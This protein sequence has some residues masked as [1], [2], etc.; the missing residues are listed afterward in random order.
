MNNIRNFCILAHIDHGKSTLADRFLEMTGSVAERKMRA[1]YLDQMELEKEKGITIKMQPVRMRYA[2]PINADQDADLRGLLYEDITYQVRGAVFNVYNALG[3]SFKESIYQRALEEEFV[4][5]GIVFQKE[6]SIPVVYADKNVGV[7]R[8]DFV[9]DEKVIVEIKALPF[10]GKL[11]QKQVWHYLKGSKYRLALLINFGSKNL[12]IERVVY[13]SIRDYP[14]LDPHKSAYILNL[15][16]TPGHADFSY[17]VSRALAAVEG[18]ILLVDATQG[19]QAQTLANLHAA[20]HEGLGIIPVINKIDLPSADV[21]KTEEELCATLGVAQNDILKISAKTGQGVE[22]LLRA[23]ARLVPPP[24]MNNQLSMAGDQPLRAL[25]FDSKYDPYLGVV[26]HIRI[27]EGILKKGERIF[28]MASG[29]DAEALEVGVF[30]PE[31]SEAA[32]LSAGEIGYVATGLKQS[33]AVRV[34][35]TIIKSK[36]Q[37]SNV[38]TNAGLEEKILPLVGYREPVPMVFAS[39]FLEDQHEYETLRN[40][41]DKLKLEDAA[42]TFVPEDAGALGRG[43]RAG[44]LGLLHMEIIAERIQREYD[45]RLVLTRPSVAFRMMMRAGSSAQAGGE[46]VMVYS[47]SRLPPAQ[48]IIS[49][50]EPWVRAEAVT[51]AAYLGSLAGLISESGGMMGDT[52]TLASDRLLVSFE[53][54]LREVIIDFYDKL[55]SVSH[56][57]ASFSYEPIGYRPG[58]LVRLDIIIADEIQPSLSEIVPAKEAEVIGRDRIKALKALLPA[59][60]FAIALQAAVGGRI[61]ARETIAAVKKDVTAHMYGGDRTRK[62]K[63]WKKQ[64]KG[65]KRLKETGRVKIPPEIFFKLHRR[66]GV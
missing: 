54:P 60:L 65:K 6:K 3:G 47:A 13:D 49:L 22:E 46:P 51:P 31:R 28:F 4:R 38:K 32:G 62:M 9:I 48:E 24:R 20:R 41:L 34:G 40:A 2:P 1:Q 37:I 29:A 63:L 21:K 66:D 17:E 12:Q 5:R 52:E 42:L 25:I 59:E 64:Q 11:E 56:G 39:L 16:D 35:D 18:A 23:V 14:R 44:F 55:K 57:F 30:L 43:F 15:I 58:D 45:V 26:A 7:Y 33:A 8:P 61:I 53:A 36:F 19:V 10:I 27:V 50:E